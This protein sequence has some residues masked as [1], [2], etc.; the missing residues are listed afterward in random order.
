MHWTVRDSKR[1]PGESEIIKEKGKKNERTPRK[2][3]KRM[4]CTSD[5]EVL[6]T[7]VANSRKEKVGLT[8]IHTRLT[9]VCVPHAFGAGGVQVKVAEKG[10]ALRP[11]V[12]SR[13]KANR[14]VS[15]YSILEVTNTWL[16]EH[17]D[18]SN[19]LTANLCNLDLVTSKNH[20]LLLES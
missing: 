19:A 20:R 14:Q 16:E 7:D 12:S 13:V 11:A 2:K 9:A 6:F 17:V 10:N 3:T 5:K 18:H 4:T 8:L 15:N 1:P